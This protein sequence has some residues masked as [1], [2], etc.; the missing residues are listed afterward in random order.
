MK[1]LLLKLAVSTAL[2]GAFLWR[3]PLEQVWRH[4]HH[5]DILSLSAATI[6]S[7]LGWWLSGMRLWCLL[8]ELPVR[9]VVRSTFAAI[10]YSTILPGQIVGDVVKA[11]QLGRQSART[12][13]AEAATLIDRVL[14]LLALL[15]IGTVAAWFVPAV[16]IALRLLLAAGA[17][18]I[19]FGG[20]IAGSAPFQ[21]LVLEHLLPEREGRIRSFM[22]HFS[23]AL[24]ECLRQPLRMLLSFALAL[25]FHALCI[26]T[27]VLLGHALHIGLTWVAWAVVYAAVS[28]LVLVPISIA[29]IGL[30]ESGYVGMLALFGVSASAALSL[31]FT[32]FAFTLLGAAIGGLTELYGSRPR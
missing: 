12:G 11:H 21:H 20:I 25:L 1:R 31:S 22:R 4:L 30:R 16:P 9:T 17:L 5:L 18:A 8:P 6:L 3:T 10:F 32:M 14:A 15:C 27:Q 26:A 23:I 2:L 13:H 28:L 24:H 29:G 19:A 7:L